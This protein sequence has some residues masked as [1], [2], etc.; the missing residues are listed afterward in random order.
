LFSLDAGGACLARGLPPRRPL[1]A[2]TFD[3]GYRDVHENAF[4]LLR[5]K[6]IPAAVFLVTQ[7]VGTDTLQRHDH[8][9]ALLRIGLRR[10]ARPA[11]AL[12]RRLAHP[13]IPEGRALRL[14]DD[15]DAFG[16]TRL[17]LTS[18]SSRGLDRLIAL[19]EDELGAPRQAPPGFLPMTWSMVAEMHAAGMTIG[20]HTR[21][22]A[23]LTNESQARVLDEALA[24]R[25]ELEQRLGTPVRHFA[26]PDGRFNRT[27]VRAVRLAGYRCA[28]TTCSHQ[29]PRHPLLTIPRRVL[30]EHSAVDTRGRFV[31]AV[32]HC[33]EQGWLFGRSG[34]TR[35]SHA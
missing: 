24:S 30:S 6:G 8:L 3:D 2:V 31:P 7:L 26:Y 15:H 25:R 28:F 11:E 35:Q 32:L 21:T 20:S 12:R 23:L 4:P 34:C 29:D 14:G 9:H 1:A 16:W 17:V 5:R 18:L 19:L 13:D 22:H 33:L 10:W 27:A